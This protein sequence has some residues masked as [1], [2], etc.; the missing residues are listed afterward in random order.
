[1]MEAAGAEAAE[2]VDGDEAVDKAAKGA[3]DLILMDVRMPRLDGLE[4]TRRIRRQ[5]GVSSAAAILAVTADAMPEDAARC[6]AA[7]MDGHLPK[8]LTHER[9]F[10]A[11]EQAFRSAADRAGVDAA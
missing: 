4:A 2:A 5:G 11:V 3:F 8:P 7:G 1:M 10:A 9:L 6:L